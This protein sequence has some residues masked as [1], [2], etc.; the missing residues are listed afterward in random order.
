MIYAI[1]IIS[2]ILAVALDQFTKY[3]A[4]TQLQDQPIT[5]IKGVFQLRY[6]ENKGAAFGMFQNQQ[7]FFLII[8]IIT[9]VFIGILYVRM[10]LDKRFIPL[11]I[12]MISITSG[13]IG[14]MIDRVR[15]QY[16]VDFL[17]FELIDF[18]VFNV[19]DIYA[20]VSTTALIILFMFYYK[21]SDIDC[22]FDVLKPRKKKENKDK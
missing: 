1:G 13:A 6:L 21:E 14:N 18:P 5:I 9:L 20:T 3:L 17:Y 2:V 22:L 8:G 4:I 11:R 10:P 7:A 15:F 16:V 19:A 12:C